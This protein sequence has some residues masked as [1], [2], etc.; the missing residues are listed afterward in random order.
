M[1]IQGFTQVSEH[2][3][4][5]RSKDFQSAYEWLRNKISQALAD[6]W[7]ID[8]ASV[9]REFDYDCYDPFWAKNTKQQNYIAHIRT[10]K[11]EGEVKVD[12]E[13]ATASVVRSNTEDQTQASY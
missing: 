10:Q 12:E 13:V 1:I 3:E 9:D 2:T 5:F 4:R 8:N 11:V 7:I 6:G